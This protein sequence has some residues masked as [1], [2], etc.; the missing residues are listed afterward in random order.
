[1]TKRAVFPFLIAVSILQTALQAQAPSA[2]APEPA[3]K[4]TT[5]Q[6]LV[7]TSGPDAARLR[8][9]PDGGKLVQAHVSYLYKMAADGTYAAAGPFLDG[10]EIAGIIFVKAPTPERAKQIE[11]ED[12]AVKAGMFTVEAS[13]FMA[14]EG[15]FGKWAEFPKFEQ[16]FFGF[17]VNGPNR[18]QDAETAKRLQAE[19][20]AYMEGQA[21]EGKLVAAGPFTTDGA[22]RGI[23]VYRVQDEA[24]ARRR[25]EGDPMIKAGRLAL[26]LH[27]WQVPQGALPVTPK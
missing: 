8:E 15:W 5:Y 12:P 4:M 14:P 21:K 20:L 25:G 22:R 6:L 7:L 23:V 13:S 27:P 9:T 1:M 2:E 19:H 26:E 18:N 24:E 16:V 3:Y 10:G 11:A 17:L